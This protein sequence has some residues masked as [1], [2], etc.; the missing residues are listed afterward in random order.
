VT[1]PQSDY[2]VLKRRVRDAGLLERQPHFY[3]R[4]MTCK[5][6]LLAAC[7]A[8]FVLFRGQP[9]VLAADAVALAI[10][11]GQLG[12]QLHDAGH[13]Q[14]F[15]RSGLNTV[16]GLIT[17]NALLGMSYGWWVDKHNKHHANPNEVDTDPDIGPGVVSYSHEQ[18]LAARGVGRVVA[19]YQ[20][21]LFTPLLFLLAW[22]MHA[23]SASFLVQRRSRHGRVEVV[24]LALHV[25]LYVGFFVA[26]LGPGWG[27]AV[28]LIS[29]CCGGFY[30]ASVFA[31]NHKG[32]PQLQPG[33]Q[34]DFLRRQVLTSRNVRANPLT[35]LWYGALNYQIEHHLFP[36]MP[37]NRV[38]RAHRIV[39]EFCQERGIPYYQTSMLQSYREIFSFLH[40][41]GAPLRETHRSDRTALHT[42]PVSVDEPAAANESGPARVTR[43]AAGTR[44]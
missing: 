21:F 29:Q 26:V 5:L 27:L 3:V 1:T 8:V 38:A 20:A 28:I 35:D 16:V 14:M 9:W 11:F 2:A 17:G 42:A 6:T 18:A 10:I 24:F 31:P 43:E 33:S 7:L 44:I 12:F 23:K 13:R 30:L 4:S 36:T 41:V 22:S 32:M 37:R 34:L 15:Q 40:Q 39:R 19:R 25:L